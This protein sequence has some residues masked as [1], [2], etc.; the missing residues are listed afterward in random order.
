M[1]AAGLLA[2]AAGSACNAQ[3]MF[4]ERWNGTTW[5]QLG[6]TWTNTTSRTV[7]VGSVDSNDVFVRI[8]GQQSAGQHS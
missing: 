4:A 3:T 6:T 5:M 1:V 2:A 8:Y 7:D